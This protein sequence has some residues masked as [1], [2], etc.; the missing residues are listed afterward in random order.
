M[1]LWTPIAALVLSLAP[2]ACTIYVIPDEGGETADPSST[3]PGTPDLTT[4]DVD[5]TTGAPTTTLGGDGTT[6]TSTDP[7][8]SGNPDPSF[9]DPTTDGTTGP[10][11]V[12][13]DYED[14]IQTIF[15]ASCGCH[16]NAGMPPAGL[17]LAP[18][19][20]YANLVNVDS[21]QVPGTARVIPGDPAGS[22]LVTKLKPMPPVGGQMPEGGMLT[23]EEIALIEAWISEGAPTGEFACPG[24]GAAGEPA[25]VLI[26]EQGPLQVEVG[27]TLDL[28]L[29]VLDGKGNKLMGQTVSWSSSQE[30]TL[31]V[32]RKGTLLGL[33]PGPVL[34]TGAVGDLQSA[35]I[36]VNVIA[37]DP[38]PTTF[39][40]VLAV[41]SMHCATAGCHVNGV[42]PA[43]LRFDSPASEMH[44]ALVLAPS[45][46]DPALSRI[47]PDS[48]GQSYV[49][50][51]LIS[52]APAKGV[53]MPKGNA[54][55]DSEKVQVLLRW[56][57]NG[58]KE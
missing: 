43:G 3:G 46:Q 28:D 24:G 39:A 38:T 8:P 18:G 45:F 40:E 15:S 11:P 2:T 30:K 9:P 33:A 10:A 32:D 56:I 22:Y 55:L 57:L 14:S 58:A 36:E 13:C 37:N 51:K 44:D 4:G 27:E 34:V 21:T 29:T 52:S 48:P 7:D 54:P 5:P 17:L 31:Y 50:L 1:R 47:A 12:A 20:S 49:F 6:T 42:A 41:T 19:M 53:P 25:E 35:P 26:D 16:Q 23:P